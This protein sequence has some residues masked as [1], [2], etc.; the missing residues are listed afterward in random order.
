MLT[1][2]TWIWGE[3]YGDHYVRRLAAGVQR[4]L[5]EA[6]KFICFSDRPRHLPDM[7]QHPILDPD[8]LTVKGCFARLRLFDPKLQTE[9]G[10]EPG[11]RIVN[12][13]LDLIATGPLDP[14][15]NRKDDFT[16]LQGIN[17]ANPCPYNGSIWMF[18]AGARPDVWKDFSLEAAAKVPFH[19]FPD[20][21]GWFH[22][23]MPDAGSWGPE[24][25]VYGFRKEGWPSGDALPKG[26]RV[27]AFPGWR[28]PSK[29]TDL[30]WVREHWR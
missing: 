23:K 7:V 1:V 3:R 14:L 19:S 28:D 20:D 16:I 24:Q 6:H 10:I 27:V 12:L 13:D 21:Q 9:L 15:F 22:H 11:S 29:F 30:P 2:C 26:A 4:N 25:G 5:S 8:L 18:K 17:V